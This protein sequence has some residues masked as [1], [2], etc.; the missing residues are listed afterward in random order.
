[1]EGGMNENMRKQEEQ[2]VLSIWPDQ[3]SRTHIF[4]FASGMCST[5]P[6]LGGTCWGPFLDPS[7]LSCPAELWATKFSATSGW[8]HLHLSYCEGDWLIHW[9]TK[10]LFGDLRI[11]A[12]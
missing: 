2:E 9:L 6:L 4:S 10:Q 5:V 11:K 1:V 8:L 12:K 7:Q 3:F